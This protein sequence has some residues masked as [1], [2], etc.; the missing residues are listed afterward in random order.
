MV[1][2]ILKRDRRRA[3]RNTF[4][5]TIAF[6]LLAPTTSR[7]EP[8]KGDGMTVDISE[9]GVAIAAKQHLMAGSVMKLLIPI[10]TFGTLLPVLA[11]IVWSKPKDNLFHAGLQFLS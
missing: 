1:S 2:V 7:L 5:K 9:G 3:R 10:D 6:E 11:K 8:V 4:S